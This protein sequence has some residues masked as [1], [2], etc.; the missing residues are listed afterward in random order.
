MKNLLKFGSNKSLNNLASVSISFTIEKFEKPNNTVASKPPAHPSSQL[1]PNKQDLP[2]CSKSPKSSCS[3]SVSSQSSSTK[4]DKKS[5]PH[6]IAVEPNISNFLSVTIPDQ[7][8]NTGSPNSAKMGTPS[9]SKISNTG[10]PNSAK[11]SSPSRSNSVKPTISPSS[12]AKLLSPNSSPTSLDT[13]QSLSSFLVDSTYLEDISAISSKLQQSTGV[14]SSNSPQP[15]QS[16]KPP[17]SPKSPKA[18][19][20]FNSSSSSLLAIISDKPPVSPKSPKASSGFN[21]SSS[22]LLAIISDKPPVSPKSPKLSSDLYKKTSRPQQKSC[23]FTSPTSNQE[24]IDESNSVKSNFVLPRKNEK[25]AEYIA[26]CRGEVPLKRISF[27]SFFINLFSRSK[28]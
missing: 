27:K 23:D 24:M 3:P 7:I 12:Q 10:S 17:V 2:R 5:R 22:S 19:S 26:R 20:G 18:S 14:N 8:T 4:S 13:L 11:N 25:Y 1:S 21:S 16:K 6:S 28:N 15:V 9:R